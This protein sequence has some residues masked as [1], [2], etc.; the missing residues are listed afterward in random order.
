MPRCLE[1]LRVPCPVQESGAHFEARSV[2]LPGL[3]RV[4]HWSVFADLS[5]CLS[6]PPTSFLLQTILFSARCTPKSG[7]SKGNRPGPYSSSFGRALVLYFFYID[8]LIIRHHS[9]PRLPQPVA[10]L[11]PFPKRVYTPLTAQ[12]HSLLSVVSY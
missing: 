2:S 1:F 3:R 6:F 9:D 10:P 5:L 8:L 12:S 11:L 7:H 4:K